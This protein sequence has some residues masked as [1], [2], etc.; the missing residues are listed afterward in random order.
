MSGR[1]LAL[2]AASSAV[3]WSLA[4]RAAGPG[5]QDARDTSD[6]GSEPARPAIA[7]DVDACVGVPPARLDELL[8]LELR[9]LRESGGPP[10]PGRTEVRVACAGATVTLS[11]AAGPDGDAAERALDWAAYPPPGRP[12]LLAL[13]LSEMI[14]R[15]WAR[16]AAA[17]A[18]PAEP[19]APTLAATA[20]GAPV[21]DQQPR[22]R[23]GALIAVERA[24]RPD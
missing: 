15:A 8:A 18:P 21:S 14:V 20:Q 4:A 12:R 11:V 9:V 5:R 13:A 7:L 6:A 17:P 16:E 23:L 24:G 19:P 2:V 22:W 1:P 10:A 3:L